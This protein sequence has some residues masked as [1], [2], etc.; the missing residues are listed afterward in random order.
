[1]TSDKLKLC[2]LAQIAGEANNMTQAETFVDN[3]LGIQSQR[4]D[5]IVGIITEP[6]GDITEIARDGKKSK[7]DKDGNLKGV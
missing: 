1:M 4:P 7:K 2:L 6:N 3:Q 5:D